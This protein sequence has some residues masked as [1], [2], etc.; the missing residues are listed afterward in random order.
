M[1]RRILIVLAV[2][3]CFLMGGGVLFAGNWILDSTN[4]K[5]P[6]DLGNLVREHGGVLVKTMDEVGVAVAEFATREEAEALEAHGFTVMPDV[7]L[8]FVPSV[9]NNQYVESIGSDEPL[10]RHQWFHAV[11]ETEKVWDMGITG[12]GVRVAIVDSGINYTNPDLYPNLDFAASATFVPGTAD[13]MDDHG[14]GSHVAGIVAAA[15]NQWGVIGVAP[16]ATIIGVKVLNSLGKGSVSWIVEGI[17][18]ATDQNV[19]IINLSLGGTLKKSGNPP[20]YTAKDAAAIVNMYRK[21]I[22]YA[23]SKGILV[24][25]SAGNDSADLD[26]NGNLIKTPAEAGN[27]VTVSAT[28]PQG[29]QNFDTPSSYTNYGN[30]AITV[31]AP[32]GDFRNYPNPGWAYDMVLSTGLRV[33]G[34]NSYRFTFMAGTS[35]AAPMV[36]G[37]AA[38]IIS[39]YG[40][41]SVGKL[42][43]HIAQTADDLGKPGKDP[44]FGRGRIN[45]YKA[46]TK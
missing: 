17:R 11:L 12:F 44:Y 2:I 9:E 27:G 21:A 26:H 19:D 16:N 24:V 20:D 29:L 40:K 15:N 42:K 32:G 30:S 35:Q 23:S 39:K 8:E 5:L 43:N 36:S 7:E 46:V 3:T 33:P 38:L 25:C 18:H 31:A 10:F 41:M 37:V 14:H 13:F 22:H 6:A 1:Q 45:A 4:G 28:G 34:T